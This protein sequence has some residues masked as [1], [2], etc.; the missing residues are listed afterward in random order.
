M[1][2]ILEQAHSII[3]TLFLIF[4]GLSVL[5]A[6]INFIQKKEY[7]NLQLK[8]ARTTFIVGHIQLLIG[9]LLWI[10]SGHMSQLFNNTK[11]VMSDSSLRLVAME[12]PLTNLISIILLSFGFIKLKKASESIQKNKLNLIYY[13]IAMV[14]ILSRIP[15]N[16]WLD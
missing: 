1:Y 11:A 6:L 15:W 16:L 7:S 3:A 5:L 10:N 14:L 4:I 12:H 8:F 9:I 13:G 2:H